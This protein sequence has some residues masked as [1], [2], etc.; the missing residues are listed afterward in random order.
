MFALEI[1]KLAHLIT[2]NSPLY[3]LCF[4]PIYNNLTIISSKGL[5][6]PFFQRQTITAELYLHNMPKSFAEQNALEDL[7]V[8]ARQCAPAVE[9]FSSLYNELIIPMAYSKHSGSRIDWPSYLSGL[10]PCDFFSMAVFENPDVPPKS[11]TSAVLELYIS[12][13]SKS[14]LSV[15]L[16]GLL[17][18][19]LLECTML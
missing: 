18:I 11:Q 15:V 2:K 19:L 14:I 1:K 3:C 13:A 17:L 10:T 4:L 8:H 5:I 12:S 6:G 16:H 9:I 7:L